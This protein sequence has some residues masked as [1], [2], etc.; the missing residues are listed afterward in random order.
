MNDTVDPVS[1][2]KLVDILDTAQE[3]EALVIQGLLDSA[4]IESV[5]VSREAP[6]DV[7]PGVGGVIIRVDPEMADE[8]RK[9][10]AA[11]HN[12]EGAEI[13]IDESESEPSDAG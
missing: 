2:P 4:G 11:F 12:D 1:H 3:S 7:L 10:I 8:A 13:I 5:L 6:Q 9:V